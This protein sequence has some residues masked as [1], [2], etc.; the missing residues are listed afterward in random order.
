[1]TTPSQPSGFVL[2]MYIPPV[3]SSLPVIRTPRSL[4]NAPSSAEDLGDCI[5]DS[6][7]TGRIRMNSIWLDQV[8]LQ[9]LHFMKNM[10]VDV[11]LLASSG[12]SI[13]KL[14]ETFQTNNDMIIAILECVLDTIVRCN[15]TPAAPGCKMSKRDKLM[16]DLSNANFLRFVLDETGLISS[17]PVI[18]QYMSVVNGMLYFDL[19]TPMDDDTNLT[20]ETLKNVIHWRYIDIDLLVFYLENGI[21]NIDNAFERFI[22]DLNRQ[23]PS[24]DTTQDRQKL[25]RARRIVEAVIRFDASQVKNSNSNMKFNYNARAR[26]VE[27]K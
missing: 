16:K 6:Y 2:H 27:K 19:A 7:Q 21:P 1:M 4:Q 10:N 13:I 11:S 15:T 20:V 5:E 18:K 22:D 3:V 23:A 24:M 17:I 26:K 9:M 25:D 14:I 8:H 12:D